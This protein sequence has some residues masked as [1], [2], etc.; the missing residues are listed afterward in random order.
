MELRYPICLLIGAL[1]IILTIFITKK[2]GRLYEKGTKVA[3]TSYIKEDPYYQKVLKQY[4]TLTNVIKILCVI[5]MVAA[6]ILMARISSINSIDTN[7]YN[8][9]IF[10]CMD[11]SDSV[12]ELNLEIV[13]NMKETVNSLKG[14][15]FGISIFNSSNVILVPLTDDYNYVLDT[16]DKLSEAIDIR[17]NGSPLTTEGYSEAFTYLMSGTL[18]G[19]QQ[20]GSSLIS[21]GLASCVYSFPKLDEQERTRIIIFSTDN[22]LAGTPL[23]TLDQAAQISKDKK[24]TVYGVGTTLMDEQDKTEFKNAVLKTGGEFYEQSN[25]SVNSIVKNIE[26]HSKTLLEEKNKTY[27]IDKPLIPFIFLL[28]SI[29][30]III[31]EKRTIS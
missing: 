21:D 3:N 1:L 16:L 30:I 29:I 19:N 4:T 20:R 5:T 7:E 8:R 24:V 27:Q 14:E 18:E 25:S 11:V 15:R 2:K 28:T 17:V 12:N 9:D 23:V 13:K 10:L 6:T 22:D 31:L 26:R